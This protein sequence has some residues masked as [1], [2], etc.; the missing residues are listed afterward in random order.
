MTQAAVLTQSAA[1]ISNKSAG[2]IYITDV[3][4]EHG[5]IRKNYKQNT[6]IENSIIESVLTDTNILSVEIAVES[7]DMYIPTV[8]I[9]GIAVQ[10][11]LIDGDNRKFKGT[12]H[13]INFENETQIIAR[14]SNGGNY[15]AEI[16]FND[17][18]ISF[19]SCS[20]LS[21]PSNQTTFKENDEIIIIGKLSNP[22]YVSIVEY[23]PFKFS[24]YVRTDQDS[25]FQI[26][27]VVNN[28][29]GNL[30][31]RLKCKS[32]LGTEGEDKITD[33]IIPIENI[34]IQLDNPYIE[35]PLGQNAIKG[36]EFAYLN[37]TS[38]ESYPESDY[39]VE[40]I[41]LDSSISFF[42][43]NKF[44][45][46]KKFYS[47][48]NSNLESN[49][50]IVLR[51]TKKSN[52]FSKEIIIG[53][54]IENMSA[55]IQFVGASILD[56]GDGEKIHHFSIISDI[57]LKTFGRLNSLDSYDI[58]IY[59]ILQPQGFTKTFEFDIKIKDI[60]KRGVYT[61]N[62]EYVTASG[63]TFQTK[64]V[65][66][67][68]GFNER[69]L[70]FSKWPVRQAIFGIEVFDTTKL[71]VI[72]L[73]KSVEMQYQNHITNEIDRFCIVDIYNNPDLKGKVLYNCDINNAV[74]NTTGEL[75][76]SIQEII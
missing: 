47:L 74:S 37:I 19:L 5:N 44:E 51:I 56:S 38:S 66:T 11:Q 45:N 14:S 73:S 22:G 26:T 35:Y 63:E 69:I 55:N 2:I 62:Y 12:I 68:A 29:N 30:N 15:I 27:G 4:S 48:I 70:T 72:N 21:V 18:F 60:S 25:N 67:V 10:L 49:D 1:S 17:E 20:I 33:I 8:T 7:N 57:E 31:V 76:I 65:F 39:L 59:P 34:N 64:F 24:D 13:D 61:L 50:N 41:S 3:F 53:V 42:S 46:K 23:G 32:E 43:P 6:I 9:N 58:T 36:Q 16:N 52:K 54:N 28:S 71:K 40:Y 75:Q